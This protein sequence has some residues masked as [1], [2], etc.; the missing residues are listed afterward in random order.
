MS[1][2]ARILLQ[3]EPCSRGLGV[4]LLSASYRNLV[5]PSSWSWRQSLPGPKVSMFGS[6]L[7]GL[8]KLRH[9]FSRCIAGG[10]RL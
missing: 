4:D 5:V 8:K 1:A 9:Q 10:W 3:R 7:H 6:A 2:Y